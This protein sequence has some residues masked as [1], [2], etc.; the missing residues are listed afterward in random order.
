VRTAPNSQEEFMGT[1]H[2]AYTVRSSER[3][4]V[5]AGKWRF[6]I[7]GGTMSGTLTLQD[8]TLYRRIS[9]SRK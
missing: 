7:S 9:L 2:R 5:T 4:C 8:G 3:Y 1:L 6:T